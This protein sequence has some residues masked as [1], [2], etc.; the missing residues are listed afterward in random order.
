VILY[1]LLG[2]MHM[3]TAAIHM[4]RQRCIEG[5]TANRA[6]CEG[7]VQN[8]IGVV[9]VFSPYI[10]YEN[11]TRIAHEALHGGKSVVELIL[12]QGLLEAALVDRIMSRENLTGPSAMLPGPSINELD[13]GHTHLVE[14][15]AE[16][17]P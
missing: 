5:I 14:P 17:E 2:S 3:L 7:Y 10:G 9:T 16:R 1:N 15:E 11:A 12:A 8:S 4:L 6:S 13:R